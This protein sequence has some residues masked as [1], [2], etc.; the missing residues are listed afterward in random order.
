MYILILNN[1]SFQ[2]FPGLL[3]L[4]ESEPNGANDEVLRELKILQS[5]LIPV[6]EYN[7]I[8]KKN[9]LALAKAEMAKQEVKKKLQ[10]L[11]AKVSNTFQLLYLKCCFLYSFYHC[12][13]R[14]LIKCR[15]HFFGQGK[16]L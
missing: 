13:V 5:A 16:V 8:Q 7:T 12:I 10:E 9:V 15:L 3:E 1:F 14:M 6:N 4:N 11:D 2:I